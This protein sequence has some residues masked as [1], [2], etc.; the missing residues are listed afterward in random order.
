M[1]HLDELNFLIDQARKIAGSDG[2]VALAIGASRQNVS[3][4]RNGKAPC[5]PE[6]QALIAAVAGLD[7][8]ITLARATVEKHEGTPTGDRLL[9]VLGKRLPAIGAAIG[10]GGAVALPTFLSMVERI[11]TIGLR[12]SRVMSSAL[13]RRRDRTNPRTSTTSRRPLAGP[14]TADHTPTR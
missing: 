5:P 2:K 4:W 7:P 9:R 12:A 11:N 8:L 6:K 3:N 14:L 13:S 1:E 10:F